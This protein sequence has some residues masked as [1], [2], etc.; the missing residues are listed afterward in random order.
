MIGINKCDD[1]SN[2]IFNELIRLYE[3]EK[4]IYKMIYVYINNI[5]DIYKSYIHNIYVI[6]IYVIDIHGIYTNIFIYSTMILVIPGPPRR[7][8]DKFLSKL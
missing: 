5:S 4:S 8:H 1:I 6:H 7:N 3:Y 2:D